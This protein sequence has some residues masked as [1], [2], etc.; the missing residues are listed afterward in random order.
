MTG[1]GRFINNSLFEC[2]KVILFQ[3]DTHCKKLE[4]SEEKEEEEKIS[5]FVCLYN[6]KLT[7]R[8]PFVLNFPRYSV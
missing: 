2:L 4:E 5:R 1:N 6:C 8:K 3:K 7:S